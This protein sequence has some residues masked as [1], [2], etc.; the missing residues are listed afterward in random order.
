MGLCVGGGWAGLQEE[1][2]QGEG[3]GGY[4]WCE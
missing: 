2:V 3:G 4:K 1:S